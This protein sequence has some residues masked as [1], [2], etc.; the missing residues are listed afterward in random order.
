MQQH[1]GPPDGHRFPFRL[2]V[3]L[4]YIA[5]PFQVDDPFRR[6]EALFNLDNPG[7]RPGCPPALPGE[8]RLRLN[9]S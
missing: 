1:L 6:Q 7:G 8:A 4:S 9:L 2:L 5:R 3:T